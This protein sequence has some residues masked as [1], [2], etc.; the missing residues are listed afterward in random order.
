MHIGMWL[1]LQQGTRVTAKV[2][3]AFQSKSYSDIRDAFVQIQFPHKKK[4]N[5]FLANI[6]LDTRLYIYLGNVPWHLVI[7]KPGI[8]RELIC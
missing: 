6:L 2:L 8:G 5:Q 3:R 1:Q 4:C 7:G